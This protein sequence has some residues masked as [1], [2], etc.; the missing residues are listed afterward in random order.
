MPEHVSTLSLMVRWCAV[1]R[2]TLHLVK[3]PNLVGI[4]PQPFQADEF[5]EA[6]QSLPAADPLAAIKLMHTIRWRE[7]A[8][9]D[10]EHAVAYQKSAV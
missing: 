5:L 9:E 8:A 10:G 4:D 6:A 7:N 1:G 3:L 2:D